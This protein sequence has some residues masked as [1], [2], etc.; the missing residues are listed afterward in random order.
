MNHV[1]LT[2][3]ELLKLKPCGNHL[4]EA[5]DRLGGCWT[6][7]ITAAQ[8][9]AAGVPMSDV[10]W[11]ASALARTAPDIRRRLRLWIADCAAHVL[12][13]YETTYNSDTRP[14]DAILSAR[15]HARGEASDAAA[16]G[17]SAAA[18]AAA[19]AAAKAAAEAAAKAAAAA[20]W[21]NTGITWT[22]VS[23][24]A[25]YAARAEEEKWQYDRLCAWLGDEEPEDWPLDVPISGYSWPLVLW[26]TMKQWV[27]GK[28]IGG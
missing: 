3:A 10:L 21:A 18:W 24:V 13:V 5:E 26:A 4:T 22:A 8:A 19:E 15:K 2:H 14:R 17:A 23:D 6:A 16:W 9:R 1:A 27:L 7:A 20:G 11:V 25:F 28:K 12:H